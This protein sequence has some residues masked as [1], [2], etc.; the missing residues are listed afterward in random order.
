MKVKCVHA[1][2]ARSPP[3]SEQVQA[4]R[5]KLVGQPSLF[6]PNRCVWQL[7]FWDG[8]AVPLGEYDE[9]HDV[10]KAAKRLIEALNDD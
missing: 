4:K 9:E 1:V 6:K 10:V 3:R 7:S 2:G 5:W 8:T